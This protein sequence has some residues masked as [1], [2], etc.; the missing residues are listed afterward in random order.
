MKIKISFREVVW[1]RI[2]IKNV[3]ELEK[4]KPHLHKIREIKLQARPSVRDL[5]HLQENV[6]NLEKVIVAPSIYRIL[7]KSLS[8]AGINIAIEASSDK[9]GRPRK[10]DDSAIKEII[11]HWKQRKSVPQISNITG[12][13]ERTIYY[14]LNKAGLVKKKRW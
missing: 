8:D 4:Y 5:K 3:G 7:A 6:P 11:N 2:R 9:R 14:Y 10:Y 13:P 12:I 1:M